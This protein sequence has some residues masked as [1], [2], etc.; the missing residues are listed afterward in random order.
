M[1]FKKPVLEYENQNIF[2]RIYSVFQDFFYLTTTT[3]TDSEQVLMRKAHLG[4][5]LK[6]AKQ[7]YTI[8]QEQLFNFF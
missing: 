5:W 6:L 2:S 1:I 4:I 7:N 8:R 3:T